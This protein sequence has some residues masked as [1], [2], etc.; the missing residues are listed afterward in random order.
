MEYVFYRVRNWFLLIW[1][2]SVILVWIGVCIIIVNW[3]LIVIFVFLNDFI[4]DVRV[5]GLFL[6]DYGDGKIYLI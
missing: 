3:Y 5:V 1:F 4:I 6:V 2:F